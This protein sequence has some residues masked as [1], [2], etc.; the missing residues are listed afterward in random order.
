MPYFDGDS[1]GVVGAAGVPTALPNFMD[2]IAHPTPPVTR[3]EV[4]QQKKPEVIAPKAPTPVS[5]GV[6]A[7]KLIRQVKPIYPQL[8]RAVRISGTVRL[9]AIIGKG[10][11]I[12]NL[13]V[14][15]GHPMLIPA[16][17][18]AVKQ[19]LYQPTLLNGEPVDVITQI[20]VNFTLSQ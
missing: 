12:E 4:V 16:A 19:W 10:G 2:T 9:V 11:S 7:A 6:Q 15:G 14:S 3:A 18:E 13:Q 20:D 5:K 17:V 1:V 8:A